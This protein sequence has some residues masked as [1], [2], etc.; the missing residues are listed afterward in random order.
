MSY[1]LN[2]LV[3]QDGKVGKYVLRSF[4]QTPLSSPFCVGYLEQEQ[5]PS[6]RHLVYVDR[7]SPGELQQHAVSLASLLKPSSSGRTGQRF[8]HFQ[9]FRFSRILAMAVLQFHATL[10]LRNDRWRSQHISIFQSSARTQQSATLSD[11]HIQ[12]VLRGPQER[13]SRPN[14]AVITPAIPN[15][16]LFGLA[17]MRIEVVIHS[18]LFSALLYP[19][20]IYAI[21]GRVICGVN[22]DFRKHEAQAALPV[23]TRLNVRCLTSEIHEGLTD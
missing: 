17:V 12:I 15:L 3:E 6:C 10:W 16:L 22:E 9:K 21:I 23:F 1:R 20:C 2:I 19:L 18:K 8:S 11:L 7:A 13:H 14:N 4:L 5:E